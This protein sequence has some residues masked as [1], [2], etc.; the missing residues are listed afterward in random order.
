[1]ALDS[2]PAVRLDS[3]TLSEIAA[4]IVQADR[5]PPEAHPSILEK[6]R[7]LSGAGHLE[8]G[9]QHT[10]RGT[11]HYPT[12]D[13][14]RAALYL[15]FMRAGIVD[16]ALADRTLELA[17]F[18]FGRTADSASRSALDAILAAVRAADGPVVLEAM[19]IHFEGNVGKHVHIGE[20]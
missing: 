14:F 3:Y 12:R 20:P 13:V 19:T 15:E 8:G 6:L 1:M 18:N 16:A 17:A 7:R 5:L 11:W 2:P 10:G 9:E 4:I